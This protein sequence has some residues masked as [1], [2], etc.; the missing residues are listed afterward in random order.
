MS[1]IFISYRKDD[2]GAWA[3]NLRD[4]LVRQFGE[5]QVFFDVD[6]IGPGQ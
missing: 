4:H 3:I 5:R 2:T 6:S 1:G